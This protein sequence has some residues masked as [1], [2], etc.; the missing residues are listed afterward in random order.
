MT[1]PAQT[2]IA[3]NIGEYGAFAGVGA[4]IESASTEVEL[5][6]REPRTAVPIGLVVLVLAY[7]LLRRR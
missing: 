2:V 5:L 4:F 1:T 7:F 3:Q 6:M